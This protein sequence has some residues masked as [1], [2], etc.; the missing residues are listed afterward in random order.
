MQYLQDVL[1]NDIVSL[2]T[3][4]KTLTDRIKLTLSQ[5][6]LVLNLRSTKARSRFI[7][8]A[9]LNVTIY[10]YEPSNYLE[11]VEEG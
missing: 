4:E 8:Q 6:T 11:L 2:K 3:Q 10:R 1:M 7:Q 9:D 5:N